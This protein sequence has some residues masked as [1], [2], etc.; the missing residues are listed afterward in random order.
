LFLH[1]SEMAEFESLGALRRKWQWILGRI[2]AKDAVRLHLAR[3]MG[4]EM[5]HPGDAVLAT[6][7]T[8]R[9]Y[10][11]P[12]E[13][14]PPMPHIS[15]ARSDQLAVALASEVPCG[16][17]V[18]WL[19]PPTAEAS[20]P[21]VVVRDSQWLESLAQQQPD[22]CWPARLRCAKQAVA[23][24]CSFSTRIEPDD[25][26]VVDA[27]E[28]GRVLVR[29]GVTACRFE[30]QTLRTDDLILAYALVSEVCTPTELVDAGGGTCS[31]PP[32]DPIGS[33]GA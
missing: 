21:S 7:D 17:G 18:E 24:A 33:A 31:R 19:A 15:I 11:V 29:H 10:V 4:T 30:A 1:R 28:E 16:I 25:L 2:A 13:G 14:W 32:F 27:E 26:E 12:F 23:E 22:E 8:G 9:P 3:K 5:V 20:D 6:G